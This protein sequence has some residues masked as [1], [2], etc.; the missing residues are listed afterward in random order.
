MI[1]VILST[2]YNNFVFMVTTLSSIIYYLLFSEKSERRVYFFPLSPKVLEK[3]KYQ[4]W[5]SESESY[6]LFYEPLAEENLAR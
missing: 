5:L 3:D 2:I 4:D 6:C 1:I